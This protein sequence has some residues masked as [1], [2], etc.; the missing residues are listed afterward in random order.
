MGV[1]RGKKNDE[2]IMISR[3]TFLSLI[4]YSALTGLASAT[5]AAVIEPGFRLNTTT[6]KFTPPRWTPGL[7]L[8]AVLLADPHL[9][10]PHM[11]LRRWERIIETANA[12][13]PD[14]N[15]LLGDYV[16]A[17]RFRTAKVP[18]KFAAQAAKVLKSSLGTFAICGNHDWWDDLTAQK[19]GLG[20]T[21]A[22]KA[23][24]DAGIPVMENK[25]IRLIKD[26]LPF[27]LSGTGSM[28]AI[29]NK[30][31]TTFESRADI[32]ATMAMITDDA[33]IIHMA[34]EP[35]LF[36]DIPDRVSLTLSGHTHG[37]Q[38]RLFGKSFV[39]PSSY[40][41]RFA[42]GHVVEDGKHLVVSGGL[43]CSI[44]PIRFGM[45]PEIVVLELG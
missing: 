42:Y 16:T 39:T 44:I 25:A 33:P 4:W 8:R 29:H 17:H 22:Q 7:K 45:P 20:P 35:D 13:E 40:G 41:N 24:E 28:V 2:Q 12:L 43:G 9:V 10:E 3:R 26:G 36:P 34:H 1:G 19:L 14:I 32:P 11:P 38:I 6:Y 31:W 27:W 5:Y 23:F 21:L 15:L 30:Y 18:V 37:G